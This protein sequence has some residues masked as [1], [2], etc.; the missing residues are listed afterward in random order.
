ML[1][2]EQALAIFEQ[3]HIVAG[4]GFDER[5]RRVQVSESNAKVVCIVERVEEVA[6]ERVDVLQARKGVDD[7]G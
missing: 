1:A 5:F 3:P 6:V 2:L 7:G 4:D